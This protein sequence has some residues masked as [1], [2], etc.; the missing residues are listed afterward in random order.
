[1][2][3]QLKANRLNKTTGVRARRNRTRGSKRLRVPAQPQ[4]ILVPIDLASN[5]TAAFNKASALARQTGGDIVL[6]HVV[7][8][9]GYV[10][11]F[12]YGPVQR[13]RTNVPAI[14][15]A[16]GRLLALG[17]KHFT[18]GQPWSAAVRSGTVCEEIAKAAQELAITMIVLPTRGQAPTASAPAETMVSRVIRK[19]GC[20]VLTLKHSP[21]HRRSADA[22]PTRKN[23]LYK[24]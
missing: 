1:M 20:P 14:R 9:I 21:R 5:S 2:Q 12:G 18:T 4:K 6:L 11:D 8:P 10:H 19:V 23:V 16:A 7:E 24:S 3:T 13:Q 15:L 22:Q 17:R